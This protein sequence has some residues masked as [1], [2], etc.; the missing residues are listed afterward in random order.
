MSKLS[1]IAFLSFSR[2]WWF[3]RPFDRLTVLSNV[4]GLTTL[5][6]V[7]GE[8]RKNVISWASA[9]EIAFNEQLKENQ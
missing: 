2:R 1:I 5:C 3:D 4:E 9:F 8:S 7:E 6:K